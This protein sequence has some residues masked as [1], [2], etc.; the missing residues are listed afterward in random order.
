MTAKQKAKNAP[1]DKTLSI[2]ERIAVL[3][4]RTKPKN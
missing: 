4:E 1:I 2:L 3:E